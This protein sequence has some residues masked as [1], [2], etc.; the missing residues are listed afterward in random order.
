MIE[1]LR[2]LPAGVEGV[3]A[4]GK[5]TARDYRTK[6][7]PIFEQA[8]R[9]GRQ[10]RFLYHVATDADFTAGAALEDARLGLGLHSLG[11]LQRCALVSDARW[12]RGAAS[13]FSS[14][15]PC[16][17]RVFSEAEWEQA[18]G[19]LADVAAP[20]RIPHELLPSSGV[21]VIR[22]TRNIDAEDIETIDATVEAWLKTDVGELNGVIIHATS[23]PGWQSLGSFLRHARF[24]RDH[25]RQIRR[26]A[27]VIDGRLPELAAIFA[28]RLVNA[29][30]RHF[31]YRDFS[32]AVDWMNDAPPNTKR[33][34]KE[35][36]GP[37]VANLG[38]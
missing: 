29:E 15:A 2:N 1:R 36:S 24:V 34:R 23:F 6:V 10:I 4:K 38:N 3:S 17:L 30:V 18:T 25:G 31:P 7:W 8:E 9:G 27:L 14:I 12:M 28:K 22:P 33:P 35:R 11:A 20:D 13:F 5:I 26:L 19:W 32:V 37:R 21:L 16:P